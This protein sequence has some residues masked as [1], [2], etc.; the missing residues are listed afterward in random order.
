MPRGG[1]R[2]NAGGKSRWIHG[3]TKTIRVPESLAEKILTVARM[4][5]EG[6]VVDDVTKSKYIDLT[7][8]SVQIL[9][10]DPVVYIDDLVK[11]G[12]TVRPFALID[13][14]LKQRDLKYK[15][16]REN[17]RYGEKDR[18]NPPPS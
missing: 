5:D 2:E 13:K 1:R 15:N 16:N 3:K 7:G 4:I 18:N 11:T 8:V 6:R 17:Q 14:V 12:F 10:G 9:N